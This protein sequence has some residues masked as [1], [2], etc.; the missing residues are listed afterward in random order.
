MSHQSPKWV[1]HGVPFSF[2]A[3]ESVEIVTQLGIC[4]S[5]EKNMLDKIEL[6]GLIIIIIIIIIICHDFLVKS[7]RG[8][9]VKSDYAYNHTTYTP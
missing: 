4:P 7:R 9:H 2:G 6:M 3:H 8:S 5:L 1:I